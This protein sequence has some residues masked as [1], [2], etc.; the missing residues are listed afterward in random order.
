MFGNIAAREEFADE[1][2][3]QIVCQVCE[4]Q[5]PLYSSYCKYNGF[6]FPALNTSSFAYIS[7][8]EIKISSPSVNTQKMLTNW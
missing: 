6:V 8:I 3:S 1:Y 4:G 5:K 2:A 7:I